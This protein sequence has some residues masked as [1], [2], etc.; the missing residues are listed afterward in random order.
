MP[1]I[2]TPRLQIA[3][4]PGVRA[5]G[6]NSPP[7]EIARAELQL[8]LS[9]RA[10]TQMDLRAPGFSRSMP[11]LE[12]PT[13]CLMPPSA[14]TTPNANQQ[15]PPRRPQTARL[16]LNQDDS[17]DSS[18]EIT[19]QGHRVPRYSY[20]DMEFMELRT[21]T[22]VTPV[23]YFICAQYMFSIG[24]AIVPRDYINQRSP[25]PYEEWPLLLQFGVISM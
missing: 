12:T 11:H 9:T 23:A 16:A 4:P 25:N 13:P 1:R 17:S 18:V 14:T 22:N 20:P 3:E 24:I 6:P 19:H 2:G 21:P 10:Q 7:Q 8:S 5:Q 15:E